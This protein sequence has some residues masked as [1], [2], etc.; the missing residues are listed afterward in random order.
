M[1][2]MCFDM[3]LCELMLLQHL[4]SQVLCGG[5]V[6]G[7]KVSRA[8]ATQLP[9]TSPPPRE[10]T[11]LDQTSNSSREELHTQVAKSSSL[12][13]VGGWVKIFAAE[14]LRTQM[15]Q[16]HKFAKEHVKTHV[17]HKDAPRQK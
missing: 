17:Q 8:R 16:Q 10:G 2:H 15:L 1:L 11:R 6:S 7:P 5:R 14:H 4:G 12:P 13:R 9:L 3:F